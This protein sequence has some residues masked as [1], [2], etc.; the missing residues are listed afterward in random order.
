MLLTR[1]NLPDTIPDIAALDDLLCRP[2]QALIDDLQTVDGDIMVL[3]VAGKMGPT[4]AGLAKA[5]LPH[6]R[7]IGVARFSDAGAKTWLEARGIETI[8]CDLRDERPCPCPGRASLWGIANRGVLHRL[9]LSVRADRRQRRRRGAGAQ[10]ARRIR[11]ILRRARTHVRIFLAQILNARAPIPAELR[12][13]HALRRAARHRDQN[14]Q[15]QADR[16]Q[17]RPRQFHLAR[18][19]LGPGAAL[20]GALRHADLADQ[21]QRLRDPERARPRGKIRSTSRTR[22]DPGRRRTADGV[23]HRYLASGQTVRLAGCRYRATDH[24]DRRLGEA[25]DAEPRQAHQ[26]RGARWPI[27]I[28]SPLSDWVRTTRPPGWRCRRKHTGIRTKP[29]GVFSSARERCSACA[30]IAAGWSQPPHCCPTRPA[31]PGS[32]WC[33]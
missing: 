23:A 2:S 25:V 15:R 26:I 14:T 27:L 21:C 1:E 22:S 8:N 32:A 20:P 17:P 13:R 33:W 10:S 12:H 30:M 18:R 7:I 9:R 24:L 29:T 3:G 4:L 31:T 16:R 28:I 5:A 11:A 19:C 6:R